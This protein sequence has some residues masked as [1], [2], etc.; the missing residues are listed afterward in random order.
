MR[1]VDV[2]KIWTE[3]IAVLVIA[4]GIGLAIYLIGIS[5]IKPYS[6]EKQ[7]HKLETINGK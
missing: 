3:T 1:I 5:V 6:S 4:L 2:M 7:S